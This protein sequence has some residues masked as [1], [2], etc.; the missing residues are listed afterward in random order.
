MTLAFSQKLNNK[1][2]FFV[3]KIWQSLLRDGVEMNAVEFTEKFKEV[4]PL[5][6]K[7][8]IGDFPQ[9]KHTIRKDTNN[10]W[11]AGNK[12]HFV[13]NNRTKNRFQFAPIVQ[14]FSIQKITIT[15]NEEICEKHSSEPAVFIDDK[16]V[17]YKTIEALAIND[18]FDNE[19]EFFN[20]FKEDFTGKIIHWTPLKY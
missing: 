4:L 11:K 14:C 9:K 8:K 6:G 12:I 13:I 20:Y 15:Y 7:A 2:T 16:I 17:D 10:K 1:P 5:I 3:E 18:G 19:S